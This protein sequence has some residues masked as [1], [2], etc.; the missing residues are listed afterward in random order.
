MYISINDAATKFNIS[1][2]RVQILCEQGRIK[3]ANLI[4]GMWFIPETA[5][6]PHDLRRKHLNKNQLSLFDMLQEVLTVDDVCKVLSISKATA[7]NWI[8]LGKL[9]PDIRDQLFSADYIAKFVAKLKSTNNIQLKKRRNKKS[10][11]GKV[12]YKDYIHTEH[13]QKLAIELLELSIIDNKEELLI[14][15]ANFAVQLYY[16]C[17]NI[18]YSD[19]NV[20]PRFLSQAH[21][22][23][24]DILI[25]DLLGSDTINSECIKKLQPA[26]AKKIIFARGEDSLGLIYISLQDIGCRKTSGSYY[27]PEKVVNELIERLYESDK[28]LNLKTIYDPCCGTGN[29][30]LCLSKKGIDSSKLY[31]QD[32][33]PISVYLARINIALM[34]PGIPVLGLRSR[35]I[36]GNTLFET[37]VQKFDVILGNPP[38]GSELSEE[39]AFK[40]SQLFKTATSKKIEI[41]DLFIEKTLS[42]LNYNGMLAFVLPEAILTV[43]AHDA[44]R[45]LVLNTCSFKFI[46][47]LGNV[48]SGVLC[49]SVILGIT[50][51]TNRTIVGCR[52]TIDDKSFTILQQRNL[53]DA[54]FSFNISDDENECLDAIC[55]IKNAVYLKR[56]AKFALGIVTGNNEKFISKEKK[57]E[58]EI[59]LKGS[60]ISRYRI[61]PSNNY[62]WFKPELFQQVA[63]TEIYRTK[64]KLLYRFICNVPVFAYDDR[65]MLPLNSCNILIPQIDGLKI[66][67]ILAILNSS[68]VAYFV[69]KKFNSVKLLRSHIEQ[70]P[71]PFISMDIQKR[72]IKKVDCIMSSTRNIKELYRDLDSDII[73]LYGLNA[74]QSDII[75]M[76]LRSQRLF[77]NETSAK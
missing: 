19:N 71:I 37:F 54:V 33:D 42:M 17:H 29:F 52:V 4:D 20:L 44:V 63:P 69:T 25:K 48:F 26:L 64:E 7:K 51:D 18:S 11:T 16:Q 56:N 40:C 77:L 13:N 70:I 38:W 1:R 74:K 45:R 53:S 3:G 46:S 61:T 9:T 24:F 22:D 32:I 55:H 10:I 72:I 27:T 59:I 28:D 76:T 50:P 23:E 31:G 14:I 30:L 35:I 68:V 12:L 47:Y 73:K 62:I 5:I 57:D 2:R 49:P 58:T 43:A 34:N 60:D 67:Y 21:S 39:D 66:K 6:K 36:I 8:R 15:L 65:Q 41:Y 75:L